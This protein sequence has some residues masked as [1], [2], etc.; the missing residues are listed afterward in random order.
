MRLAWRRYPS[1][2]HPTEAN[3]K[4]PSRTGPIP[5]ELLRWKFVNGCTVE[6]QENAGLELP[7]NIGELADSVTKID[8]S[9]HNLRGAARPIIPPPITEVN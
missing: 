9:Q 2:H 3:R 1:Y 8:L 6:L 5:V 7:S 4:F